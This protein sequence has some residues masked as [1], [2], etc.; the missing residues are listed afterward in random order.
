MDWIREKLSSIGVFCI[1]AGVFSSVLTLVGYELRI[2]RALD[3]QGPGVA[4]GVRIGFIVVGG[5]LALLAPK[6][7]P[8]AAPTNDQ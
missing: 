7:A 1:L 4:W 3:E 2:F 6:S 8:E 5:V